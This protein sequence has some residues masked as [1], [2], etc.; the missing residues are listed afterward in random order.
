MKTYSE[1]S[2]ERV[3]NDARKALEQITKHGTDLGNMDLLP[4]IE[5]VEYTL[6]ATKIHEWEKVNYPLPVGVSPAITAIVKEKLLERNLKQRDAATLLGISE[7]RMSDLLKG[8]RG[9]NIRLAKK[10]RDGLGIP[11]DYILDNL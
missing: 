6:L 7:A 4:D 3:Y 10:L 5:K 11:A 1:I 9:I 2:D 8:K